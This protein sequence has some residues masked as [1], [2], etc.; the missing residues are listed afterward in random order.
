MATR[1]DPSPGLEVLGTVIGLAL[2]WIPLWAVLLW[3]H[4]PVTFMEGVE[5]LL[6]P[7]AVA[8]L[9]LAAIWPYVLL[10]CGVVALH[11]LMKLVP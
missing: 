3:R 6:A 1:R 9:L 7:L 10:V 5:R 2:C 8:G 4:P 11:R